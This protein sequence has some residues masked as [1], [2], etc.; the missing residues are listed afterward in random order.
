MFEHDEV[1]LEEKVKE[2]L[3]TKVQI[4][5]AVSRRPA[6]VLWLPMMILI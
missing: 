6:D 3:C 4:S 5:P 1:V 2:I